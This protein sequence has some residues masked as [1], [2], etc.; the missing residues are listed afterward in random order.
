[1]VTARVVLFD[2]NETVSDTAALGAAFAA[3]G[4]P[5]HLAPTWF[6]AVLRDGFALAAAGASAP[7]ADVGAAAARTL[8]HGHLAPA[9][10]DDAVPRILAAMGELPVHPD[11]PAGVR[12][13]AATGLRLATLT[14]GGGAVP[15]AVLGRAGLRELFEA[16][17]SVQDGPGGAWKPAASAYHRAVRALDVDPGDVVLVAAHPWDVDGAHRAGLRTAWV[18]RAGSPYPGGFARPDLT[19]AGLGELAPLLSA[20]R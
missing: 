15:A 19:V 2:V 12:A 6:A 17:L 3:V 14:N 10:V 5:E 16:L 13:L 7:F 4:A 11:V 1:M 8:L 18:D 9:A 20:P